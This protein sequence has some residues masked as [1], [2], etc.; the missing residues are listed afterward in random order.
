MITCIDLLNIVL[1]N[2][3]TIFDVVRLGT[4]ISLFERNLKQQNKN[5]QNMLVDH[6]SKQHIGLL[7]HVALSWALSTPQTFM[8]PAHSY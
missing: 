6:V 2:K 8:T 3:L 4:R 7:I 5:T 1:A